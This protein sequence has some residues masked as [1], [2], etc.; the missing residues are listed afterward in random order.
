MLDGGSGAD[1]GL[2]SQLTA[3]RASQ[4]PVSTLSTEP[5]WPVLLVRTA[6]QPPPPAAC[7][8]ALVV[9]PRAPVLRCAI[10]AILERPPTTIPDVLRVW[11]ALQA[12]LRWHSALPC[13]HHA[14]P[15]RGVMFVHRR[16]RCV[17]RALLLPSPAALLVTCARRARL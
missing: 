7:H 10:T 14:M 1:F 15:D 17:R 9:L 2:T 3:V 8:V 11:P 16:V 4:R 13:A 5:V 6:R 12:R